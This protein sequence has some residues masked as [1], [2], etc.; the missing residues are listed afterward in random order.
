MENCRDNFRELLLAA[1]E[2]PFA[3]GVGDVGFGVEAGVG[4]GDLERRVMI[5]IVRREVERSRRRARRGMI[6][7]LSGLAMLF[8]GCIAAVVAWFPAL[9]PSFSRL[10]WL[11]WVRE[12]PLPEFLDSADF[13]GSVGLVSEGFE[14]APLFEQWGG[15][16]V[17]LLLIGGAVGFVYYL[18]YLFSSNNVRG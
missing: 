3:E 15:L 13:V 6:A 12:I 7:S 8:A 16:V 17:I 1:S 10:S 11:E 4:G 2:M 14:S 5:E 18:N 9:L